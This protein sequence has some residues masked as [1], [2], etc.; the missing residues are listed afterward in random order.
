MDEWIQE[1]EGV[2]K[3]S[4]DFLEKWDEEDSE[5][6]WDDVHGGDLPIELVKESRREEVE[7]IEGKPVWDLRRIEECL[8]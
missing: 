6:A 2:V 1:I 3:E 7:F 8:A 5:E 4:Q